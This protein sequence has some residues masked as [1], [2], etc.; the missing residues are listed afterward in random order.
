[1]APTSNSFASLDEALT[2]ERIR[3]ERV[4]FRFVLARLA[5]SKIGGEVADRIMARL[6]AEVDCAGAEWSAEAETT[7]GALD[8]V[9]EMAERAPEPYRT[10]L[11]AHLE[12]FERINEELRTGTVIVESRPDPLDVLAAEIGYRAARG[13]L[14]GSIAPELASFVRKHGLTTGPA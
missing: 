12:R 4:L 9:Q 5:R 10:M 13:V 11:L 2:V 1:M 3:L 8:D 6:E 14:A 7:T